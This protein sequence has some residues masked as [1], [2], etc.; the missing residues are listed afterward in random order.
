MAERREQPANLGTYPLTSAAARS[1]LEA[2]TADA[3]GPYDANVRLI[4]CRLADEDRMRPKR[5]WKLPF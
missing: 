3:P 1:P 2:A 5:R 4:R